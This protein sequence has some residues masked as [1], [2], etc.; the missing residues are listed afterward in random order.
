MIENLNIFPNKKN[1]IFLLPNFGPGGAGLSILRLCKSINHKNFNKYVISLGNNYYKRKFEKMNFKVIELHQKSLMAS[2]KVIRK[3]I[4]DVIKKNEKKTYL[5]SNINYAN[6]LSC[7]FFHKIN[8]L[9]IITIERTPI[10]ELEY[11][12]SLI[13]FFKNKIIKLLIKFFYKYA[14]MRIGNSLPVSK[15][16]EK[17]CSCKVK[18]I[19]PYIEINKKKI[20][21]FN[22]G[23]IN[24]IW[25]GR[26][27]PEKNINDILNAIHYLNKI[28]FKLNI[29]SDKKVDLDNLKIDKKILTNINFFKFD[30]VNL[31]K[32]YKKSD[33]LIST[34]L[35]E[36]FP[37]VIAEAINYNCLIISAK[38]FGGA[39]Q[40]IGNEDKGLYYNL[41][42]PKDLVKKI[43]Y[44]IENKDLIV[45]KILKSKKNLIKLSKLN[46]NGYKDLFDKLLKIK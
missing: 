36:G 39:R 26:I 40:L 4:N 1:L 46:N 18:T 12:P 7:F 44:S 43:K 28:D 9:K 2:I 32:M 14:F 33:I 24:L 38:N 25:I 11:S 45:K 19:T 13:K 23:K 20:K 42:D 31:I 30:K 5:I 10:Q 8:K 35:Y 3:N 29:I 41:Y 17:F 37:N 21:K 22:K 6:A 15:D 16:L 27:S 34:S